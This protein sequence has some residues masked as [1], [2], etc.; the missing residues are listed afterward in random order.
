MNLWI[1]NPDYRKTINFQKKHAAQSGQLGIFAAYNNICYGWKFLKYYLISSHW[2]NNAAILLEKLLV[3]ETYHN[4]SEPSSSDIYFG[5]GVIPVKFKS[6]FLWIIQWKTF[7]DY[8]IVG[9]MVVKTA[10]SN[11]SNGRALVWEHD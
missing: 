9:K 2:V 4:F 8:H 5:L 3:M 10:P 7:L 6:N 1:L 11:F